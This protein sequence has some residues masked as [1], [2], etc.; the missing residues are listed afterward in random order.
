LKAT[1]A[2][3]WRVFI[4]ACLIAGCE[5]D[6]E[7]PRVLGCAS[8]RCTPG[9]VAGPGAG[10]DGGSGSDADATDAG[11]NDAGVSAGTTVTGRVAVMNGETFEPAITTPLLEPT[12]VVAEAAR[13]GFVEMTAR[14]AEYTLSGIAIAADTWFVVTPDAVSDVAPTLQRVDTRAAAGSNGVAADLLAV[15]FSS[16]DVVLNVLTI[17]AERL[18]GRAHAVL[19]IVDAAGVPLRGVRANSR[20]D[21]VVAYDAGQTY[22]DAVEGTDARGVIVLANVA[23]LPLPGSDHGRQLSGAVEGNVSLRLAR[24]AITFAV[25]AVG[26]SP[27]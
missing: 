17:P 5:R 14:A 20:A 21:E 13:G 3:A 27:P 24:D 23:A 18:P 6:E 1:T 8:G 12:L 22:S 4:V 15:R 10:S 26:E 16:L 9:L 25:V 7:R 19:R 11:G 2:R